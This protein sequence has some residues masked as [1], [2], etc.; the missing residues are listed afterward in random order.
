MV[1]TIQ[2]LTR[3][4]EQDYVERGRN[5]GRGVSQEDFHTSIRGPAGGSAQG[6]F[7]K[8]KVPIIAGGVVVLF[9]IFWGR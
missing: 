8:F 6:V 4:Q 7:S 1:M 5:T 2:E 9:L 3:K